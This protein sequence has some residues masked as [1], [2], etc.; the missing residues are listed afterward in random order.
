MSQFQINLIINI[1][2]G[3]LFIFGLCWFMFKRTNWF[4]EGGIAYEFLKERTQVNYVATIDVDKPSLRPF[5]DPVLFDN[6]IYVLII[7]Y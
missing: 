3:I 2:I 6:K 1:S 4:K 5:G 7:N